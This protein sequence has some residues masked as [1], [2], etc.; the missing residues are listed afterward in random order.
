MRDGGTGLSGSS[1]YQNDGPEKRRNLRESDLV[2]FTS[3]GETS[4]K[5]PQ[6]HSE[7]FSGTEKRKGG[8]H[9]DTL[10][11][12]QERQKLSW[13]M[14][15]DARRKLGSHLDPLGEKDE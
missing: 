4:C 12:V 8:G 13:R 14:W 11:S 2:T 3:Q 15:G 6:K 5:I 10:F 1:F 9:H 7:S